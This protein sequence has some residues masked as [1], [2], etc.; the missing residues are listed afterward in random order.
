MVVLAATRARRGG[1]MTGKTRSRSGS[2]TIRDVASLAGVAPITVSRV[3]NAPASVKAATRERVLTAIAA[4]GYMPNLVAGAL[5]SNRSRLVAVLVPMLT[6]PLFADSYQAVAERLAQAGYQVLLGVTGHDPRHEE[7][8]LATILSRRP[9][10][11]ILTGVDHTPASRARLQAAGVP[12]VETW[13]LSAEPIDQAVGFHHEAVGALLAKRAN[14]G[15]YAQVAQVAV[16]DPRGTRRRLSL[17]QALATL[18]IAETAP[19]LFTG[20]PSLEQGRQALCQLLAQTKVRPLLVVCTSDTL[21]HGVLTEALAQGLA[22]PGD[23]AVIGF[24]DMAFAAH[25]LP[26]LT[27]IRV[28]ATALGHTAA[29]LLLARL[30]GSDGEP[31][32]RDLGVEW[33]ER[34]SA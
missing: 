29:E 28:D 26:A 7:A 31:Q 25:T 21:A 20:L 23:V 24:G 33:I 4:S 8:L 15:G 34:G 11:L 5:A 14:A 22:V 17:S 32:Q 27:T 19:A 10:G 3:V 18:G 12:V 9:D 30:A 2:V 13:D 16:D 1:R 6:N